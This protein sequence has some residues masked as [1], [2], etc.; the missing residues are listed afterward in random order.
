M[1]VPGQRSDWPRSLGANVII[2]RPD[3]VVAWCGDA[4]PPDANALLDQRLRLDG[5]GF[6]RD[7]DENRPQ[8]VTPMKLETGMNS[9][10]SAIEFTHVVDQPGPA[11]GMSIT[12]K[13]RPAGGAAVAQDVPL[14]IAVPWRDVHLRLFRHTWIFPAR[15]RRRAGYPDRRHRPSRLPRQHPCRCFGLHHLEECRSTRPGDRGVVGS[16]G[17][18]HIWGIPHRPLDRRGRRHGHRSGQSL[19]AAS[20]NR[21]FGLPAGSP[22]GGPRWIQC[23]PRHRHDRPAYADEG[24]RHVRA[25]MDLRQNRCRRRATRPTHRY[26]A[27]S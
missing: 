20:R 11:Y 15:S 13:R 1:A 23:P 21:H 5:G 16:M 17:P 9:P 4:V 10:T 2:V 8:Q 27:P 3:Q 24:Q 22:G 19:V 26:R 25:G 6:V 7:A 18:G 14:I 12:G